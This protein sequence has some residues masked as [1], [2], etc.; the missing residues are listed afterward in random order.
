M[1]TMLLDSLRWDVILDADGNMALASDP[2]SA[3]QDVA[4]AC[5]TFLGEVYYATN[6][7]IPYLGQI[8]GQ[9]PSQAFVKAQ[10]EAAA[11]TVPGVTNPVAFITGLSA[12]ELSGQVQF[13]DSNGVTQ[14]VSI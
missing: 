14:T 3:A 12:R 1:Q 13:T 5:R 9:E 6:L 10:L 2:Y 11:A 8:L 7:G 4:S